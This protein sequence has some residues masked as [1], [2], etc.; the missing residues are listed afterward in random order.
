MFDH[1]PSRGAT[2]RAAPHKYQM[3][4]S[5]PLDDASSQQR[6][7][8][9]TIRDG[10]FADVDEDKRPARLLQIV[11]KA[12]EAVSVQLYGDEVRK[13]NERAYREFANFAPGS[14]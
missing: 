10:F 14:I 3:E 8:V 4:E 5:L 12:V 1:A 2:E 11:T 6:A 9:Q 7:V 13:I